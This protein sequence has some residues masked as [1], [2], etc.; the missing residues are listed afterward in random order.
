MLPLIYLVMGGDVYQ[1]GGWSKYIRQLHKYLADHTYSVKILCRMGKMYTSTN[2]IPTKFHFQNVPTFHSKTVGS[3]YILMQHLPN[4]L[5]VILGTIVLAKDVRSEGNRQKLLHVHALDSSLLI[6]LLMRKIFKLP[7]MVQIHGFPL[8]EQRLKLERANTPLSGFVWLLTKIW[9]QIAVEL[10]RFDAP[11]VFVN[12]SEVR[13]FYESCGI[14]SDNIRVVPSAIGLR[15]HEKGVLSATDAKD[16]L[17]IKESRKLVVVGYIG[18][19]NSSK[20]IEVLIEAFA[21]FTRCNPHPE[22]LLVIVGDGFTRPALIE[23]VKNYGLN[24]YVIFTGFIPEAYRLLKA[25]DIFVLP[26]LSEGSPH[27]LIEAMASGRSI[28][29]S[30]I[31]AIREIVKNGKETLLF[32]PHKPEQLKEAILKLYSSSELR[33]KLGKNAK[34]KARQY[35]V[36]KVF[37]KILQTYEEVL[38]KHCIT[39]K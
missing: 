1:S 22:T 9:H 32:D 25:I 3:L 17:G 20:N 19:L 26:S 38:E 33:R 34:K 39:G 15:E 7:F 18:G 27:S 31:R 13:C 29:A 8:R 6:A 30:N 21:E 10:V 14:H 4:P 28:I 11:L 2:G 35:D 36:D 23:I 5:S 12:N 24:D 37:P 16:C